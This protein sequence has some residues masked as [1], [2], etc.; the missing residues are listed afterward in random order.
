MKKYVQDE[1]VTFFSE[2]NINGID[3]HNFTQFIFLT[4]TLEELGMWEAVAELAQI[5]NVSKNQA[6]QMLK[7]E[8]DYFLKH[9]DMYL[10]FSEKLY[11]TATSK[12]LDKR[13]LLNLTLED[14][15]FKEQGP[16][17][18]FSNVPEI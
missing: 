13:E 4:N 10:I 1:Y 7:D 14:V 3:Y 11:D 2:G 9:D 16:F 12:V 15:E 17:Y 8:I 18:Y 6:F 5:E